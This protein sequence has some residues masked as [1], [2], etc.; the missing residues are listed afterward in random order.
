LVTAE[1]SRRTD[2]KNGGETE[3]GGAGTSQEQTAEHVNSSVMNRQP[4]GREIG[5]A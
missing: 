5:G 2:G 1:A 4:G 3:G